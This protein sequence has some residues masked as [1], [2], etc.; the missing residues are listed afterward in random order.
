MNTKK[1]LSMLGLTALSALMFFCPLTVRIQLPAAY[2]QQTG[3]PVYVDHSA[4]L[5]TANTSQNISPIELWRHGYFIQ[6]VN[7]SD[8]IFI[9]FTSSASV[10]GAGSI[11]LSPGQW[12]TAS[13]MPG[14][15]FTNTTTEAINFTGPNAGDVVTCKTF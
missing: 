1:F 2:S 7:T 4:T 11:E 5:T 14:A 9:N 13:T 15:T 12:I 10:N 3:S 6:N 8:N